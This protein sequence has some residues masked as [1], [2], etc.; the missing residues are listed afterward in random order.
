[1]NTTHSSGMENA[2]K[3]TE[4]AQHVADA[5]S[6]RLRIQPSNK[7]N[8][9]SD[10]QYGTTMDQQFMSMAQRLALKGKRFKI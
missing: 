9:F 3:N 2:E 10:E 7:W 5:N 4:I 8:T 6:E 1:M